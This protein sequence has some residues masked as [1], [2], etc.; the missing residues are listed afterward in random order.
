MW[1]NLVATT[2]FVSLLTFGPVI[3]GHQSA[4]NTTG[5]NGGLLVPIGDN[6][7]HAEVVLKRAEQVTVNVLNRDH[8]P[9]ATKASNLTLTFTEPDG[10]Q[11]DYQVG[12]TKGEGVFTRISSHLVH[13]VVRDKMS[14]AIKIGSDQLSSKVVTYPYG[15]N[16][17]RL[18]PLGELFAELVLDENLVQV[19][20]LDS[21]KRAT[22]V[23]AK[24]ITLTFTESDG[25]KEN[26]D[27]LIADDAKKSTWFER[28][29]DHVVKHIKRDQMSIAVIAGQT[30]LQS[31]SFF[32]SKH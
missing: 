26:Y 12:S 32:Y 3:A 30:K 19:H 20:M 17:G 14:I 9:V 23:D 1:R 27:V 25:E 4:N 7:H 10:E 22:K 18:V 21:R 13:H 28:D 31:E 24:E 29:D 8:Q 16:G 5:P 11:E 15:P 2:H 6:G